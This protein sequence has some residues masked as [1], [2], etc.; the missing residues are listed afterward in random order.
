MTTALLASRE[1]GA[2]ASGRPGH[3][4]GPVARSARLGGLVVASLPQRGRAAV[5][6]GLPTSPRRR[7]VD[8][9]GPTA[10]TRVLMDPVGASYSV[11]SC[12]LR[13]LMDQPT[14]SISPH[15]PPSRHD[16]S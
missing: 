8:H 14:E 9:L 10:K 13:I 1:C 16:H 15:D 2:A 12:D 4:V 7:D 6:A 11:T 3:L 5:S